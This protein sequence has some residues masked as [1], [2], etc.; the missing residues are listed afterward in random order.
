MKKSLPVLALSLLLAG[1]PFLPAANAQAVHGATMVQ[2]M[3]RAKQMESS[4][5]RKQAQEARENYQNYS[6][7]VDEYVQEL[8]ARVTE[9][10]A[11][12]SK[13]ESKVATLQKSLGSLSGATRDKAKTELQQLTNWLASEAAM[14]QQA[15]KNFELCRRWLAHMRDQANTAEYNATEAQQQI[16]DEQQKMAQAQQE[17]ERQQQMLQDQQYYQ[18]RNSDPYYGGYGYGRRGMIGTRYSSAGLKVAPGGIP[19]GQGG[20]PVGSG[21][22]SAGGGGSEASAGGSVSPA[23]VGGGGGGHGHR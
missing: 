21:G 15:E 14:S 11:M 23:H 10:H 19:I 7:R 6:Q 2:P 5:D 13:V 3:L 12:R 4:E 9:A 22:I 20:I 8:Q 1:P 18:A 16:A 17:L